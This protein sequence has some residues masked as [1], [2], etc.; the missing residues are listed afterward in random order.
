MVPTPT[1]PS[2]PPSRRRREQQPE[3]GDAPRLRAGILRQTDTTPPSWWRRRT[4]GLWFIGRL[5]RDTRSLR[6]L[7][8]LL[9]NPLTTLDRWLEGRVYVTGPRH[10]F[11][12]NWRH[13]LTPFVMLALM[14]LGLV[15]FVVFRVYFLVQGLWRR[16]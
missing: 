5:V 1:E 14:P 15:A 6:P 7:L 11:F 10:E 9:T 12:V 8:S 16:R 2:G 4:R 3:P 13:P